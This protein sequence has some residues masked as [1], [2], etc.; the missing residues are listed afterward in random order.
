MPKVLIRVLKWG[1][2]VLGGLVGVILVAVL[3][4]FFIG[5]SRFNKTYDIQ[6]AAVTVPTG[7]EEAIERGRHM[8]AVT[9]LCTECH[10][11]NLQGDVMEDDPVFGR[12]VASNLTAGKGG[13]GGSYSDTDF[14]RAIRHGVRPD[15]TPLVIMPS[16]HYNK[17]ND[18]D[19]GAIIAYVKSL[20]PVDNELPTTSPGPL[21]RLLALI[22]PALISAQV[23][24]HDAPRPPAVEPGI[25]KEYGEYL[26]ILC[27]ICHGENMGGARAP[28]AGPE[29]PEAPNITPSGD[30]AQW[31]EEQF[32]ST[33]RTGVNPRGNQLDDEFM[34]WENF[35]EMT[36]EELKALY[37]YLKSLPAISN[38]E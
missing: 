10:G 29:D 13:V 31:T 15:G 38:A 17:Y 4:I 6:T 26:G 25:T 24:D 32:I 5:G 27:T 3:A 2:I 23:I 21:A 8:I 14:V 35:A 30:M 16:E 19:L 36:D 7:D 18:A 12:L 37:L 22:E 33:M 11:E 34:P 1:G 20:P 9:G 28:D